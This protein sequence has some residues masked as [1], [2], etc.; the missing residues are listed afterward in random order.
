M[1]RD[2]VVINNERLL[3]RIDLICELNYKFYNETLLNKIIEINP[4]IDFFDKGMKIGDKLV[5]PETFE[6]Y[7]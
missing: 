1:S 2:I 3:N 7:E 6:I 4:N 5:L